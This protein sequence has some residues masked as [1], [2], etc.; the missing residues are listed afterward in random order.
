MADPEG[1]ADERRFRT[2]DAFGS[3]FGKTWAR[4]SCREQVNP[5]FLQM[6]NQQINNQIN[7]SWRRISDRLL[8]AELEIRVMLRIARRSAHPGGV[9]IADKMPGKEADIERSELIFGP[10]AETAAGPPLPA[11]IT[12][13]VRDH[14]KSIVRLRE[15]RGRT[16]SVDDVDVSL[17]HEVSNILSRIWKPS[18]PVL[19]LAIALSIDVEKTFPGEPQR[20]KQLGMLANPSWLAGCIDRAE[21]FRSV[22][23]PHI[24]IGVRTEDM[25]Q[26]LP[27]ES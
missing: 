7:R 21:L 2:L 10:G 4:R 1:D 15:R 26:V 16:R 20:R 3:W 23:A 25:I 27:A 13:V 5:W 12:A 22:Y 6:Q 8:A 19:H 18:K 9:V 14:A 11:T 17:D 24:G